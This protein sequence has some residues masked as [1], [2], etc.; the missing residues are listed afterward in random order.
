LRAGPRGNRTNRLS[1]KG[2]FEAAVAALIKP[3]NQPA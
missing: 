3:G 2:N 1:I